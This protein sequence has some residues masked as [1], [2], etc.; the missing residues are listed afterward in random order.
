MKRSLSKRLFPLA[1][2]FISTLGL[3]NSILLP[4]DEM[5]KNHLKAYGITYFML[6]QGIEVDWLLNYRG[7]SFLAP[8]SQAIQNECTVRGVSF[9]VISSA[10]ANLILQG[11]ASPDANMNIVRLETVPKVGV[12]SPK[13]EL[14]NDDTDAVM[15]VLDYAEIPYTFCMMK[16]Y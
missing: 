3:A 12:Y 14:V 4:M 5:Q 9:E 16:K 13:N 8:Y 1:F 2:I 6:Q 7:G 15:N 11:I 10:K